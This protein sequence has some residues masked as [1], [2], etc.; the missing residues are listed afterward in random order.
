MSSKHFA[1]DTR[2]PTAVG[3]DSGVS[4]RALREIYLKGFEICVK[5]ARPQTIMTSYNK[6]NGVWAHYNYE[7]ITTILRGHGATT[8]W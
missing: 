6:I 2:R 5:E 7:L 3:T 1:A 4:E 8:A